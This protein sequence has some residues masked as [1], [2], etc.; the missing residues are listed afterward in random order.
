[1]LALHQALL[2]RPVGEIR[3]EDLPGWCRTSGARTLSP[4]EAAER[5]AIVSALQQCGGNRV[6]AAAALG[7]A[8]S[9]LYRKIKKYDL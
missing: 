4:I 2:R 1:M 8:R 3:P 9:S 5:D 7:M 6:H